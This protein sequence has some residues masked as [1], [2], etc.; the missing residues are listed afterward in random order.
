MLLLHATTWQTGYEYICMYFWYRSIERML[1]YFPEHINLQK[2]DDG[3][4]LLHI[5]AANSS[6]CISTVELIARQVHI[7]AWFR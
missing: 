4:S 2:E 7:N 6:T 1:M 3:Y 5:A